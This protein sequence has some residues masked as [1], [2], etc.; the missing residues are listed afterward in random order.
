MSTYLG[1]DLLDQQ[2]HNM[3]ESIRHSFSRKGTLVGSG[4]GRRT[5][6][7]DVGQAIPAR[8]FTWLAN[9]RSEIALLRAFL[10]ARRGRFV[11][12]WTPTFGAEIPL[13]AAASSG[14]STITIRFISYTRT[15]FQVLAR[16]YLAFTRPQGTFFIAKVTASVDNGNGTE[17]L[18]LSASL[19]EDVPVDRLVSYL[20]FCRLDSDDVPIR[21]Q[22][23]FLAEADL[24]FRELPLE[25]PA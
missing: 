25:V 10:A 18:N 15:M 13:A 5:W 12:F 4:L 24:A 6:D 8:S 16:R 19:P 1:V 21:W 22:N 3:R 20:A 17:T 7:D 14:A 11:P 9:G 23:P 2:T